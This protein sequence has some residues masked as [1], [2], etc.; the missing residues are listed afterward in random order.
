M[1]ISNTDNIANSQNNLSATSNDAGKSDDG[2]GDI[3]AD[4]CQTEKN[5]FWNCNMRIVEIINKITHTSGHVT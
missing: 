4:E 2:Y 1:S 5:T 3:V